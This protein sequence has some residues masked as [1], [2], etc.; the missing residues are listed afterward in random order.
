[1]NAL[2]TYQGNF[3]KEYLENQDLPISPKDITLRRKLIISAESL[4]NNIR[5][6]ELAFD[7][8]YKALV[9]FPL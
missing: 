2:V 7:P 3:A 9:P 5:H 6:T 4:T 8:G 1:M